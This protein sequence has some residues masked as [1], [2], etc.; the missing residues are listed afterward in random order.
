MSTATIRVN[1]DEDES[2]QIDGLR[3]TA[4]R[5]NLAKHD[6]TLTLVSPKTGDHRTFRVRTVRDGNLE[7]KRVVELLA[8]PDNSDDYQGFGFIADTTGLLA[9]GTV[10]VWKRYRGDG[11]EKTLH[12]QLADL[13]NRPLYWSAR[14]VEY[15]ISLKCRRCGRAL[16]HPESIA[17]GLGPICREKTSS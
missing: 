12:E 2:R 7:G 9:A 5:L 14:G 13:L 8:G 4:D 15:L 10:I 16:T 1:A 3:I 17:D 6:C 11:I